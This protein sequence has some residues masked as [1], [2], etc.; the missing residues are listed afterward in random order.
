MLISGSAGVSDS[1]YSSMHSF[2]A[3]ESQPR[4]GTEDSQLI[5][6]NDGPTG[7]AEMSAQAASAL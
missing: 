2:E 4:A 7:D 5:S 1:S 6:T 3:Q